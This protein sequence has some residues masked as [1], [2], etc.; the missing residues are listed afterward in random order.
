[1]NIR[2]QIHK[3][4]N[5]KKVLIIIIVL[6]LTQINHA[7]IGIGTLLPNSSSILD[8][9]S[10]E[11][12]LLIPRMTTTQRNL[13]ASP[14]LSL[15]I[16][17]IDEGE[18]NSYN[19]A[20]LGWQDFST[21]YKSVSATGEITTNS[22][23]DVLAAGMTVAPLTRGTYSVAFNSQ[24][25]NATST[26]TTT[27]TTS[28]AGTAKGKTDLK[29]AY[30]QLR[31]MPDTQPLHAA[32]MGSGE[33]L[34]AGVYSFVAA[35]SVAG[36]LNLDAQNDPNA[37]FVFKIGGAFACGASTIIVLKNGAK[38]SNI[39]YA[40]VGS[41]SVGAGSTMIG[42]MIAGAGAG[43]ISA[44]CTLEGRLM[45]LAGA[46]TFG[47]AVATVPLDVSPISLGA[48]TSF[49]LFTGGGDI[50]N[51]AAST[52]TGNIG[53]DLGGVTG[54]GTSTHNGKIYLSTTPSSVG[55][56]TTTTTIEPNNTPSVASFS[57]YQNGN[58][59]TSSTKS[60]SCNASVLNLSLQAIATVEAN[61]P[62][63]VRWNTNSEKIALGNRTLTIIKVK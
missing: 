53:T 36:T 12:G 55:S 37:L 60:L 6:L 59:I 28:G 44:T 42:T 14:A 63:E 51:T 33:T 47:P 40:S 19:G 15:I 45:T 17:N 50:S 16:F 26:V 8:L 48:A 23:T 5:M 11:K 4:Q 24:Y 43:A 2:L 3:I 34:L 49:A 54:L 22:T 52:I 58:L 18:F 29:I 25:N 20:V 35:A 27:V 13:I 32:A 7:Q 9:T 62:I 21:A 1:M 30:D 56:S 46:I 39:F 10:T 38:A 41:P 31:A 57:I 61:Q